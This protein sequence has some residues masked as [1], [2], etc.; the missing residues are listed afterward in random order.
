MWTI[1][2]FSYPTM[3]P[4]QRAAHRASMVTMFPRLS[5]SFFSRANSLAVR[6]TSPDGRVTVPVP[7]WT[8]A[9]PRGRAPSACRPPYTRRSTA[10]SRRSSSW[11]RK[12]FVM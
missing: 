6:E 1:R 8:V 10:P 2:V 7:Q 5:A 9:G 3:G 11:G 4:S 12:G